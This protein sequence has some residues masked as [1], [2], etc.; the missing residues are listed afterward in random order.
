MAFQLGEQ[1][2]YQLDVDQ[3]GDSS[4]APVFVPLKLHVPDSLRPDQYRP[5]IVTGQFG[6][7]YQFPFVQQNT[8]DLAFWANER[9]R[10]E[11]EQSEKETE[12]ERE[13]ELNANADEYENEDTGV[14]YD[15]FGKNFTALRV[16]MRSHMK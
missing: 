14:Q 15:K 12:K 16:G 5:G 7:V 2:G 4:D 13:F 11:L 10:R 8:N 1:Q 6:Q 3:R 9:A